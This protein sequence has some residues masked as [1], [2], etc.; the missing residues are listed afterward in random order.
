MGAWDLAV[1]AGHGYS[2]KVAIGPD[3]PPDVAR[4]DLHPKG[5]VCGHRCGGRSDLDNRVLLFNNAVGYRRF[6]LDNRQHL[7]LIATGTEAGFAH[8]LGGVY[9]KFNVHLIDFCADFLKFDLA[10]LGQLI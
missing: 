4:G 3:A 1:V 2:P 9:P 5:N 10:L 8:V 7:R 6:H